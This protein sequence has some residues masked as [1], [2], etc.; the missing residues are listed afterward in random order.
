MVANKDFGRL[1]YIA[2]FRKKKSYRFGEKGNNQKNSK[3]K[4]EK[5]QTHNV[6]TGCVSKEFSNV[7]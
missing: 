1:N 7:T 5:Y 4:R 3:I 6:V 2:S